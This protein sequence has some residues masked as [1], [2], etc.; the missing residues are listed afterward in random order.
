MCV[1]SILERVCVCVFGGSGGR[2]GREKGEGKEVGEQ[3]VGDV[4]IVLEG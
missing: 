1:R 3:C 4:R 2:R